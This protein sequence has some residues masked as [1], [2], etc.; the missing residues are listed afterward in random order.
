MFM[1]Y[2]SI[3]QGNYKILSRQIMQFCVKQD[4]NV[5]IVS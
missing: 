2:E 1:N 4:A 5:A 3:K